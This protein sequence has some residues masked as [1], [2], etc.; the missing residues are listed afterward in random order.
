VMLFSGGTGA[1]GTSSG[2]KIPADP[3][4]SFVSMVLAGSL[5][6][7]IAMIS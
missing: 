2:A 5:A 7:G 6:S 1:A 3:T 4:G